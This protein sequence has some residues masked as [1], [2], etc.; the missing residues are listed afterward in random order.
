VQCNLYHANGYKENRHTHIVTTGRKKQIDFSHIYLFYWKKKEGNYLENWWVSK[1]LRRLIN[2]SQLSLSI[3]ILPQ[4]N[5][6]LK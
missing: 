1:H 2:E 5:K 3:I 4:K 6:E